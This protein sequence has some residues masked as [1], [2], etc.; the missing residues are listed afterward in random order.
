MICI[1]KKSGK[2]RT[3]VDARKRN[4]NTVKDVTPFPDQDQ[5]RM[6]VSHAKYWSKID[7]SDAYEQIWVAAE[8]VWKTAF[9]TSYGTFVSHVMQQGDCNAPATFQS[10][11][12][13]IFHDCIG[14]YVHVYLDDIFVFSD[15]IEE[16]EHHLEIVFCKL[17]EAK[18]YLSETKC[19]LYSRS[20]DCLGHLIDDQGLYAD[21]DKMSRIREWRIPRSYKEVQRFLG[22]VNYLGHFMPNVTAYTS[23]LSDMA[24]NDRAFVWCPMHTKC[25]EMIKALA[26]KAPIL[27]PIDPRQP[28]P[29]WVISDAS[30]YG[31]GVMYGQGPDWR[32]CR[33]AGFL[34]KKFTSVQRAYKT[35]EHEAL[36]ILEALLKWENKLLGRPIV[37]ATDHQALKYFEGVTNPTN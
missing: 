8:D 19:E 23:P 24:H 30:L 18:L 9:S 36:T 35:Y 31:V 5:I 15:T 20:M 25:F 3:V 12:T 26:C 11:R 6:D 17:R 1:M 22:L 4:D 29:I 21:S 16:H 32:T 28:E 27:K 2:L 7:L 13:L 14:R 34:S 10:L 37:I 33:P